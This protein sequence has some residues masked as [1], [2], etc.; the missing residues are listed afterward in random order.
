MVNKDR[1]TYFDIPNLSFA[2]VSDI[3]TTGLAK[4]AA[5]ENKPNPTYLAK[6]TDTG[7][8]SVYYRDGSQL[9]GIVGPFAGHGSPDELSIN[10]NRL[11]CIRSGTSLAL[12][13]SDGSLRWNFTGG[14][15]IA[16]LVGAKVGTSYVCC[17]INTTVAL[18]SG[19]QW[20]SLVDG[21]IV[22][23]VYGTALAPSAATPA[24]IAVGQTG[25]RAAIIYRSPTGVGFYR[26]EEHDIIAG[27]IWSQD[28]NTGAAVGLAVVKIA[29]DKDAAY[30]ICGAKRNAEGSD[31]NAT[32]G[33]TIYDNTG[34]LIWNTAV[35]QCIYFAL[36]MSPSGR[37]AGLTFEGGGPPPTTHNFYS[38]RVVPYTVLTL[39]LPALAV[40]RE[41]DVSDDDNFFVIASMNGNIYV[42]RTD[43]VVL[44]AQAYGGTVTPIA[45]VRN[46]T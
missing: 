42:I 31:A 5:R 4:L 15:A 35:T 11:V 9:Y 26:T 10:E 17:F 8:L 23:A 7:E 39:T 20:R 1:T 18:T 12:I 34:V 40:M 13:N 6:I 32:S 43:G 46:Y 19:V 29:C 28:F 33:F 16:N 36:C 25:A 37:Q 27:R 24:A 3:T 22:Q 38:I 14:T 41:V 45:V 21:S 30:V 2:A 44:G